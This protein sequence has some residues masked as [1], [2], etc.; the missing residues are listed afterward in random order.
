MKYLLTMSVRRVDD[1]RS[2]A[3]VWIG[4][5]VTDFKRFYAQLALNS[6][7]QLSDSDVSKRLRLPN[8]HFYEFSHPSSMPVR[9]GTEAGQVNFF[10]RPFQGFIRNHSANRLHIAPAVRP[11][12]RYRSVDWTEG[13]FDCSTRWKRSRKTLTV[14]TTHTAALDKWRKE[15]K[16]FSLEAPDSC[17]VNSLV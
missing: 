16:Q 6:P 1:E 7:T 9:E 4:E 17:S 8:R 5:K 11:I 3:A 12:Q 14:Y 13:K 15:K 10:R 2:L